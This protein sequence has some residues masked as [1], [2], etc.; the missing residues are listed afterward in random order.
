MMVLWAEARGV[1][2]SLACGQGPTAAGRAGGDE[3]STRKVASA[4][5]SRNT[6]S[7]KRSHTAAT[8]CHSVRRASLRSRS[9]TRT[10]LF[11]IV[12]YTC[13]EGDSGH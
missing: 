1:L 5:L 12:S 10:S 13:R 11:S 9:A 3:K 7:R 2:R 8:W 6:A 4:V